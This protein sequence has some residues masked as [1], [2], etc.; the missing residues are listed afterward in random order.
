MSEVVTRSSSGSLRFT[1]VKRHQKRLERVNSEHVQFGKVIV[2]ESLSNV[3]KSDLS[4]EMEKM[5]RVEI[6]S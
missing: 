2:F 4:I 3:R 1:H 6:K 5:I